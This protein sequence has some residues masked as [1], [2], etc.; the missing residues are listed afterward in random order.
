MINESDVM[1]ILCEWV[2]NARGRVYTIKAGRIC[3][4]LGYGADSAWCRVV[5]KKILFA[6]LVDCLVTEIQVKIGML[7]DVEKARRICKK[8]S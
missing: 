8:L 1:R 4:A 7:V 5:V 3:A 2:N 6:R